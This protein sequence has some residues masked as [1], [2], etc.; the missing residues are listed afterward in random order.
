MN[1]PHFVTDD[2]VIDTTK[3]PPQIAAYNTVVDL[4][5]RNPRVDKDLL[6]TCLANQRA[7]I[8]NGM[9]PDLPNRNFHLSVL[10]HAIIIAENAISRKTVARQVVENIGISPN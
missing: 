2:W 8:A 6:L 3:L 9:Y 7:S 4:I 5:R 10:D 1:A